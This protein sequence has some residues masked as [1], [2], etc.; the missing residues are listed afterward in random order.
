[1]PWTPL[2]QEQVSELEAGTLD[3]CALTRIIWTDDTGQCCTV[4]FECFQK[5][6]GNSMIAFNWRL[7][8]DK[9]NRENK[10]TCSI[11]ANLL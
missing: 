1:M 2:T 7:V 9:Y 10:C 8:S 3:L 6:I 5:A 11:V 4:Y